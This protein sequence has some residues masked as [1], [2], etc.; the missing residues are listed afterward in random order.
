MF[1]GTLLAAITSILILYVNN[2]NSII[3]FILLFAFG[4]F[5]SAQVLNFPYARE[6]NENEF[7]ATAISLTNMMV[8]L[9]PALS[10]PLVGFILDFYW[11][12]ALENGIRIYSIQAYQSAFIVVPVLLMTGALLNLFLKKTPYELQKELAKKIANQLHS[13]RDYSRVDGLKRS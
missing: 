3:I 13:P 1:I 12:G 11:S 2:L 8:V 6:I 9:G 7:T 4:V 5:S 10:Q